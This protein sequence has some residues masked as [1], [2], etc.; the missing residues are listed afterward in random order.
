MAVL[1]WTDTN[2]LQSKTVNLFA[3]IESISQQTFLTSF[4]GFRYSSR[5]ELG[6]LQ[7]DIID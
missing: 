3:I 4:I 1:K 7:C 6:L 5:L 2:D